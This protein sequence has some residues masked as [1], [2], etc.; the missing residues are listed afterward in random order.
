MLMIE[1]ST[2]DPMAAVSLK[3]LSEYTDRVKAYHVL[4]LHEAG[5][6]DAIDASSM[7]GID[8]IPT[9]LTMAGHQYL[10]TI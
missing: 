8:W 9:R 5:L 4:L 3:G 6:V 1:A 7:S 10:E 2:D